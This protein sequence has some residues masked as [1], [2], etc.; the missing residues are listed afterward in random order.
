MFVLS[1]MNVVLQL[2]VDID[3]Y[4]IRVAR[5]IFALRKNVCDCVLVNMELT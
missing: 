2:F 4:L 1:V 3:L 5:D